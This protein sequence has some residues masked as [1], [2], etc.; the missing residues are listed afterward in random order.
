[1]D[2]IKRAIGILEESR[3]FYQGRGMPDG[4]RR[5]AFALD[6]AISALQKQVPMKPKYVQRFDDE[7]IYGICPSCNKKSLKSIFCM[8]CGQ[9]I[10]W[11]VYY[12]ERTT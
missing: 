1:M 11:S 8:N 3:I 4:Y 12:D 10:D 9:A 2:E 5:N 7:S 6:L